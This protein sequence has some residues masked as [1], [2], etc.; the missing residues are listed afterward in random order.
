MGKLMLITLENCERCDW[1]QSKI[2]EGLEVEFIDGNTKEGMAQL[3]YHEK[4]DPDHTA[5]PIFI[6]EDE[7]MAYEGTIEI[8]NK[9]KELMESELNE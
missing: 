5:M 4:Y 6:V 1:V 3:S 2:P 8:K 7:D 9:M